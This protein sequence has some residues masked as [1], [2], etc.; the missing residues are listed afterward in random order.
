M[1]P[2]RAGATLRGTLSPDENSLLC[3][4]ERRARS[5][6]SGDLSLH[7][8]QFD[9]LNLRRFGQQFVSFGHKRLGNRAS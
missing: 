5:F 7:G 8:K 1:T 9:L 6:Q 2:S 3:S 4:T